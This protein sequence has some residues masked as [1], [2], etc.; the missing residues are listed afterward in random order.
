MFLHYFNNF[1]KTLLEIR[2]GIDH[3]VKLIE[4]FMKKL[5]LQTM[6]YCDKIT[7][8]LCC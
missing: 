1:F 6:Q 3:K 2:E 4:E 7:L 5:R 8:P